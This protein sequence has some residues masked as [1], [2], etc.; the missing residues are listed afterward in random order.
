[1]FKLVS[2]KTPKGDQPKAIKQLCE[3]LKM[4]DRQ[5][6]LG[7]TGTGKTFTIANVIQEKNLPTLVL[8]HNKTL[9]G[10]LYGE[11]KQLFP[12]NAVEYFVSNFDF[13]QPEAYVPSADLY[14]DK[15]A[16]SNSEIEMMR[17]SAQT[18][19]VTR[20]DVIVV[21]SVASIY[22]SYDPSEFKKNFM[23]I[24]KGDVWEL[25]SLFIKLINMG[26]KREK[27]D[28]APGT[29]RSKG[30]VLEI[31]PGWTNE[32][33]YRLSFFGNEIESISINNPFDK[34][35]LKKI[36]E[37]TLSPATDYLSDKDRLKVSLQRIEEELEE[38][39]KYFIKENKLVEAQR[40][41][42]RTRYDMESLREFGM[43]NGI[44]NYS[45]HLDLREAGTRPYTLMDY[46]G[47][48]WLLVVDESHITIPQIR[49]MFNTDFSRKTTLVNY[50]FRLPSALDNRP[51]NFNE[52][53]NITN[54]VIYLSATPGDYETQL[55]NNQFVEQIIR[56][57]G[58]VDPIIEVR[59]TLGQVDD[60]MGELKKI[61]EKK[62][63]A[64]ITTLTIR[65]AE[66][67][68][69]YLK[70][71]GFK[72]AYLHN[73]LKTLERMD[74]LINL[75]KGKFDA[76]IGINLLREGIDIP[77]VSLVT[78]FDADKE[79]F[80]R[81]TR[82]LIQTIG[83]AARNVEG[84]VIMYADKM[85]KSMQEAIQETNRRRTIQERY[86]IEHNIIPKTILKNIPEPI[87][88]YEKDEIEQSKHKLSKNEKAE[89]VKKLRQK[90]QTAAKNL[91]FEE[92]AQLRDAIL[93]LENDN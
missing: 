23:V 86:N 10:Q 22:G 46:Y 13:Y 66:E 62:Q 59:P 89:L 70:L 27:F 54:K 16:S 14:I 60:L 24:K 51:L 15:T 91:N 56:P 73:E 5:V 92:A 49:G 76:I 72:V 78:I 90:M 43:C 87:F 32:F 29:F 25:E 41:E 26:F 6:L 75:R 88:A 18:S 1:M 35:V 36:N 9:A 68:T 21:A 69:E 82:S 31:A 37:F 33:T 57:T 20:K 55:L 30:D 38:R 45:R 71:K 50:G 11:L 93:D 17:L 47:K 42:Q 79:G 39:I 48:E 4:H 65:M 74:V 19:L 61:I 2:D 77:E 83:R 44:E 85:T 3:N 84:K 28:M 12:E 67:L 8:A 40:I 81:N 34:S 7:A 63:R 53:E 64:F 52:F 58:L 80:L